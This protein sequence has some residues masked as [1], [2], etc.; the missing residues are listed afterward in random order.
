MPLH[1]TVQQLAGLKLERDVI[2]HIEYMPTLASERAQLHVGWEPDGTSIFPSFEGTMWAEP[3]GDTSCTL[4]IEG[5][6][7]AP[8]GIAGQVF[9]AVV[10][11]RIARG[12][13]ETMLDGFRDAAEA[14][15]AKRM[16]FG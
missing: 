12:T 8:G 16:Y 10:G 9:D 14:D 7:D 11:Q 4:F 15:Y 1:Y 2:V 6:Y 5:T 3:T 13:L